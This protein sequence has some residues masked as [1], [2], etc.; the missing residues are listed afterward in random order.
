[1][2]IWLD[3][4]RNP[5]DP[6]IMQN[7]GSEG[8]EIWV[9]TAHTAINYLKSGSVTFISLDHDLGPNSAGTGMDVATWIEEA[10]FNKTIPKLTWSIHSMNSVGRKNMNRALKRADEFWNAQE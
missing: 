4:E 10:A 8:D 7:F 1:M 3:D 2:K 9:K 6:K 5:S